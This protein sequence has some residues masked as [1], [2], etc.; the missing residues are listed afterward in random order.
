MNDRLKVIGTD[1]IA[2]MAGKKPGCIASLET[3]LGRPLQCIVCLL[4]L[5]ELPLRHI[6]EQL[7]GSTKGPGSFSGMIGKQLN[8]RASS[9]TVDNFQPIL[10]V[11]FPILPD[12]AIENL[13]SDQYYAL[14]MCQE[15]MKGIV[16]TDLKYLEVGG[17]CYSRWLT[18][19]CRILRYCVS[20]SKPS[21]NLQILAEYLV[22]IYFPC[23]FR[24]KLHNR[25]TVGSKHFFYMLRLIS[26]F[27][28]A[29]VNDVGVKVLRNNAF[30]AHHEN[31]FLAMLGDNDQKIR[32]MAVHKILQIRI[33]NSQQEGER[34]EQTDQVRMF[35]IPKANAV[36]KAYYEM[37][38]LHLPNM[39]EP[40]ATTCMS[41]NALQQLATN[42]PELNY[43]CH[44][45]AEERH[46]QLVPEAATAVEGFDRKDCMI[47]Q[48]IKSR[49]LMP[50]YDTKKQFNALHFADFK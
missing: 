17:L 35:I 44:N 41:D 33:Q 49:R 5:N 48:K 1:G 31:I 15:V 9:W 39:H 3:K 11:Q 37:S 43:P 14:L 28:N 2:T 24:I 32:A 7:N 6:F 8:G 34:L 4:H 12:E 26:S 19:G 20:N 27:S 29:V 42:K 38:D 36:A 16:D 45:Q 25:I 21:R 18:L 22:R 50:C 30:F 10:N 46:I 23:W 40:P 47:R 13:S